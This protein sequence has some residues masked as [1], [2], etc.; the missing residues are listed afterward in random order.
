MELPFETELS[1]RFR[2]LDTL[3]HVNN[4]VYA[5]YLEQARLRYFDHVLDV[6]WE[7]REVVL[8]NY[9]IDFAR[10]LTLE[11]RTVRIACG[12]T[13]VGGSSFRMHSRVF[14]GDGDDP[15]ATSNA[16]LVAVEDGSPREIPTS[17]REQFAAFE[18][19]LER[20]SR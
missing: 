3:E 10:P 8:A 18:P 7:E 4:A 19:E 17:W 2:D 20:G 14:P 15:A 16:T 11:D 5:T 1:I 9:G 13:E 12:V 6:P